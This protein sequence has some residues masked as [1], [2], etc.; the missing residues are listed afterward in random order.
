MR[1]PD[2]AS[3]RKQRAAVAV[4]PAAR[5]HALAAEL[6]ARL[7]AR[8]L[9]L[10][11][12]ESCTGGGIGFAVTQ[13]AGSSGWFD[14]GFV[15]YSNAAKEQLLGVPA[16][17]LR[18]HGAVSEAVVRAMA[19]GAL[20]RSAAQITVAVT[21][22]AGPGGGSRAKPVGTV[23]FGW[24]LQPARATTVML[25]TERHLLDGD[26]A[27]VRTRSIMVAL[28]GLLRLLDDDSN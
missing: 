23:W 8:R 20:A 11:A 15:T 9:L 26:R 19:L 5:I 16:A 12:A 6:G 22:V 1:P 4:D 3:R 7:A 28:R 24:A 17:T 13:I 21:G 27:A 18:V 14:R 2:M 25:V 10:A